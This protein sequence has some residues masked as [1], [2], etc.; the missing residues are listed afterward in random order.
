MKYLAPMLIVLT[1]LA[2]Q[3][4]AEAADTGN[5]RNLPAT[6]T[7]AA[8]SV[9]VQSQF[10]AEQ[11]DD[12]LNAVYS[13]LRS[14]LPASEQATLRAEQREWLKQRDHLRKDS[15]EYAAFIESRVRVLQNRLEDEAN[16]DR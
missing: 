12:E 14:R 16:L 13:D 15:P 1:G 6:W 8:S 11:A 9:T 2:A 7:L 4:I 3:N 5:S 10:R